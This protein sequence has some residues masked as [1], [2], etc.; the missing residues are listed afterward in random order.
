MSVNRD[1]ASFR[2]VFNTVAD[3]VINTCSIWKIIDW[4]E[5]EGLLKTS[6]CRWGV[7]VLLAQTLNGTGDRYSASEFQLR[8]GCIAPA[9]IREHMSN[10]PPIDLGDRFPLHT[11]SKSIRASVSHATAVTA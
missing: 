11:A 10:F 3:Q 1:Y 8:C 7:F 9:S 6:T 4:Y 2:R 5:V